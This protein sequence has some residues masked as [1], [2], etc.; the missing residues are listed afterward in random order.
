MTT[1]TSWRPGALRRLMRKVATWTE[2]LDY[3]GIDYTFDR[4]TSVERQLAE[5]KEPA[6]NRNYY[7]KGLLDRSERHQ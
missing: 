6:D 1:D 4:I 3:S 5:L 7:C 2:A